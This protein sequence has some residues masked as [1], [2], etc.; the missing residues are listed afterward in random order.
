MFTSRAEYR[1]LLRSD[2]A[3]Q[4]LTQKGIDIGVVGSLRKKVWDRKN[5]DLI[6][7]TLSLYNLKAKPKLLK[8][9]KLPVTRTGK[10]RTAKELL[11]S[12]DLKITDLYNLWPE[13]RKI[14]NDL[15]AQLETDC[16]YDVYLKRQS[17]DINS[18][19]KESKISIPLNFE[20]K[21]VKGLSNEVKEVL[22]KVKPETIAQASNLPGLTPTAILLLLRHVKNNK[23]ESMSR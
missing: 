18:F 14:P 10:P 15:H 22:Y 21:E 19:K 20:F 6:S 13:L 23:Q 2:N 17:E 12:G 16:R 3:D 7:S 1:L 4:R 5:K 11:T 8:E 9:Y